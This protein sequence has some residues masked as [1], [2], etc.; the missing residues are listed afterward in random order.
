MIKVLI[1]FTALFALSLSCSAQKKIKLK[2]AVAGT[3]VLD[4]TMLTDTLFITNSTTPF[5]KKPH[6]DSSK[7]KDIPNYVVL[8]ILKKIGNYY[9]VVLNDTTGYIP[10]A[11]VK[12]YTPPPEID[13]SLPD[14]SSSSSSSYNSS[15][16]GCSSSQCSGTTKRGARCRN[17]T[18][19]CSGRCY[20]H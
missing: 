16:K 11:F 15:S 7:L 10:I 2:N 14:N 12:K 4:T 9:E 3:P 6:I 19:N 20:L 18:T 5:R 17:T 1:L 13:Y 8:K